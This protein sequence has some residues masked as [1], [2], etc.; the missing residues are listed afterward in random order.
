MLEQVVG[1]VVAPSQRKVPHEPEFV[2]A[3]SAEHVPGVALHASQPSVQATLQQYPFAQY[4][5][6]HEDAVV[7]ARPLGNVVRHEAPPL[8][9]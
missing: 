6:V 7:Q 9:Q 3:A 8:L 2:P 1:Q 4:P 5:V